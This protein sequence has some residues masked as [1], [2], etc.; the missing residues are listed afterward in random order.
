MR[1]KACTTC[2]QWKARCDAST[3]H[4]DPCTR[5]RT[6]RRTCTFDRNF[7]RITK[8]KRI[9]ELEEEINHLRGTA[10]QPLQSQPQ[11]SSTTISAS[12]HTSPADKTC[13]PPATIVATST[14]P[15]DGLCLSAKSIGNV[16]FSA[17]Q[18]TELFR[19]FSI[20][21][22]PHLPM[23]MCL[24]PDPVF[25][26]CPLLF[27]AICAAAASDHPILLLQPE[28]SSLV[29]TIIATPP[30]SVEIVQGLL[31]LCMWPFP[32]SNTTEDPS[33]IYSG[34]ATQAALQMGLHRPNFGNEF[35]SKKDPSVEREEVKRSTWL[36]C[37]IVAQL[38]SFRLG[39]PLSIP[40]D[41]SFR[42][43]LSGSH[44][45]PLLA[46]L[47]RISQFTTQFNS[48]IGAS[49]STPSGLLEPSTR[50]DMIKLFLV[51][52]D[53]L[54]EEIAGETSQML[55]LSLLAS[56]LQLLSFALHDDTPRSEDIVPLY[57]QAENEAMR[58]IQTAS[59][60]NLSIVPAHILRHLFFATV[61][62]IKISWSPYIS[63]RELV[64][65]KINHAIQ[66]LSTAVKV[67]DDHT[68]RGCHLLRSTMILRDCKRTPSIRSRM[69]SSLLFDNMRVR[70]EYVD[71]AS[72]AVVPPNFLD[73]DGIDWQ[74][75]G[76][77]FV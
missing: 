14:P 42:A 38:Q 60:C 19:I 48:V 36:A 64:Q 44:I 4:P 41:F 30:R 21:C 17:A 74:D 63:Q 67:Q 45:S 31:I 69:A 57:Y 34:M 73:L 6:L 51:E 27:W 71:E 23:N 72:A 35:S 5:C 8:A 56:K 53:R 26:R 58:L 15:A 54:K 1:P 10:A 62:L 66:S 28:I 11:P 12:P 7:K 33:L 2:R 24:S 59:E 43:A 22:H 47:Y 61:M 50:I 75:L 25:D 18:V 20:R 40:V 37:Y 39:I 46:N 70:K 55:D 77:I 65:D 9:L 32:Y 13:P 29:A 16:H 52:F 68:Q 49:A 76:A 3:S